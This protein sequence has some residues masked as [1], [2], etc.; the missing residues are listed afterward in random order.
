MRNLAK[1]LDVLLNANMEFVLIGGFASV[2]HGSTMV[3]RDLDVCMVTGPD[4]IEKLR[5]CLKAYSPKHR[6]T[7]QQIFRD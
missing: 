7:P 4:Q 3:T 2:V 6:M 5:M 1:L